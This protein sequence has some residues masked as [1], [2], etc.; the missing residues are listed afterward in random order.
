MKVQRWRGAV[1]VEPGLPWLVAAGW[2]E[3]GSGDD[4]YA[5]LASDART[6]R[7][8]YNAE[9]RPSLTTETH[10]AYLLPT[11]DDRLRH[12][13]E[14]VTRFVRRLEALVPDL[15]RQSLRD[16]HERVAEFDSFDLGVQVR[17]DRG[18]ETYVAIRIRGSVPVNLVPV[19]L[20]IV[21]GCDRSGWFPEAALPDRS[22]RA[23]E[24]AWSNIMDTAVAA[25]LLDSS[26]G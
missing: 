2:R 9:Y 14:S 7:S 5:V 11:H 21:P 6:A 4:F 8:R 23:A 13:L 20:D 12:R 24:Q 25:A 19:I 15:V 3:S 22:L 26:E 18:H 16:G 17:A 10:T 1:W